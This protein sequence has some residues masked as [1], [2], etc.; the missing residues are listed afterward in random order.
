ML[1][2]TLHDHQKLWEKMSI[3]EWI[4]KMWHTHKI[5]Y[6]SVIKRNKIL[7]HATT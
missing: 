7:I 2:A 5:E 4:D 6:H 1:I 3:D